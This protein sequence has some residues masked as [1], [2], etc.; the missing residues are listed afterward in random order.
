MGNEMPVVFLV[1]MVLMAWGKKDTV[2]AKAARYPMT[3][4]VFM[5]SAKI[6]GVLQ[7][8]LILFVPW[9]QHCFYTRR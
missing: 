9:L 3:V 4:V 7:Q 5:D 2:V 6:T 8:R 1:L